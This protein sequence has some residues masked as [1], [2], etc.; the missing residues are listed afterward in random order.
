VLQA[1][2]VGF[3]GAGNLTE[4]MVG[5][6]LKKGALLPGR[7]IVTNRGNGERLQDLRMRYGVRVT[8]TKA[9]VVR[10]ADLVVLA[11]KPKDVGALLAEVGDLFRPGQILLTA[12]AGV[13]TSLIA[14]RLVEGVE[15]VRCMP[16]TSCLVGES[17]TGIARGAGVSDEAMDRCK[18]I[19]GTMGSVVA[20]DESQLDAVTGLSGSGPAY[21]YYLV[22]VLMQAGAAVGLDP[23]LARS[24]VLQ[25]IKG[26]ALMLESTGAD[27]AV[28]REQVTSPGGTTQAGLTVLRERGFRE[29]LI[30]CVGRATERAGEMGAELAAA[31]RQI[32]TTAMQRV[33]RAD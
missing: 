7:I 25:T 12:A 5:G 32:E 24:L 14:S 4:A 26:A 28:L 13:Q 6:I 8:K 11:C 27:P 1:M 21:I 23:Q 10:A 18:A 2:T 22:E 31:M 20:V 30:A 9:D 15:V 16:N 29:A 3:L 17:A 33:E 19:L